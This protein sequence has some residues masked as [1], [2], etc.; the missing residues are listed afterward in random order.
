MMAQSSRRKV[1]FV[2]KDIIS[3]LPQNLLEIILCFLPIRD[4]V[5]TSALSRAW[6]YRWT[7][8]PHLIFDLESIFHST[9]KKYTENDDPGLKA[10]S[11][12]SVINEVLLL[13]KGPI[14]KFSL[15]IPQGYKFDTQIVHDYIDQWISLLSKNGTKQLTLDNYNNL[16]EESNAH[17]FS[18]LD[19]THLRLLSVWFPYTPSCERFAN[20]TH[21]EL[22]DAT[23]SFGQSIFF[24]PVLEKLTLIICRGL[25]PNN[26]CAP[27][28]KCLI[29]VY[30]K[31]SSKY[32]L[33]GLENLEEYSLMLLEDC[34]EEMQTFNVV[35]IPGSLHKIEKFSLAD[36]S[37]KV[38]AAGGFPHK[39]SKPLPYLKS[40]NIFDID[41]GVLCEASC[42]VSLI[43]SAP[44]LRKLH[45]SNSC[46][47]GKDKLEE[48]QIEDS[49]DCT[50]LH[51]EIV[52]FSDF[53]GFVA[54]LELVKFLLACSP[55]LKSLFIHRRC[56]IK[57]CASALKITE[58]MLQYTRASSR[59]QIR[60][61]ESPVKF[62]DN[63]FDWKLLSAYDLY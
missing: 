16:L 37:L 50:M 12:V 15:D 24:C 57:D 60:H 42:L 27:N 53:K 41:F 14:L 8:I 18:V 11:F 43:R 54:E 45:I 22:V 52:L 46:N 58:E 38:L 28:L 30:H 51:L 6:R 23:Y 48:Y 49:E 59:A 4:A 44:N 36:D 21:L 17:N 20:L 32:S 2:K 9:M 13:H 63:C 33:A 61:L 31:L 55:S 39:L 40:L 34:S 10:Y 19:P 56:S 35:I 47:G 7:R 62:N 5:R 25:F 1:D 29:Q 26:F 3:E